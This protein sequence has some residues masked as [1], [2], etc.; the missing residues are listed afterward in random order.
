MRDRLKRVLSL[1][2]VFAI[3]TGNLLSLQNIS[4][5]KE[6]IVLSQGEE[7][8]IFD[9]SDNRIIGYSGEI[10]SKLE[11]PSEIDGVS[12]K[13]I[14]EEDKLDQD[15]I[16]KGI[17]ELVLPEGIE[18]IEQRVFFGNK[19]EKLELPKTL[20][21]IRGGAFK[22]NLI[23]EVNFP[24][25]IEEIRAAA[26]ENNK[27][28][29][30]NI[31]SNIE[32]I[33]DDAFKDN[34]LED[35]VIP[36]NIRE[37]GGG[38]FALNP[39]N[40][41]DLGRVEIIGGSAF[42]TTNL[43]EISLP[44]TL[45]EIGI[46]A[47]GNTRIEECI[48]PKNVEKL[49]KDAF[50]SKDIDVYTKI[51]LED[52]KNEHRLT[53]GVGTVLNPVEV[54]VINTSVDGE[55]SREKIVGQKSDGS[56]ITDYNR[57]NK[58][59]DFFSKEAEVGI[60]PKVI[61]GFL[62]PRSKTLKLVNSTETIEFKYEKGQEV[63]EKEIEVLLID[64]DYK[65]F[66]KVGDVYKLTLK[67]KN[68]VI[69]DVLKELEEK[70]NVRIKTE[71]GSYGEYIT[72][73][74]DLKASKAKSVMYNINDE[75][76]GLGASSQDVHDG[77]KILFFM[78][79]SMNG[80]NGPKWEEFTEEE[81]NELD[82]SKLIDEALTWSLVNNSKFEFSGATSLMV[83]G[84]D[85]K[86][87]PER[88][89]THF[90]FTYKAKP[91]NTI[92]NYLLGNNMEYLEEVKKYDFNQKLNN[93]NAIEPH[94]YSMIALNMIGEDYD[95]QLAS[96]NLVK[97][98]LSGDIKD[99]NMGDAIAA[100]V[101]SG[102]EVNKKE[103]LDNVN[104]RLSNP[105]ANIRYYS[106]LL[107][108][109]INLGEKV[110]ASSIEKLSEYKKDGGYATTPLMGYKKDG[111]ELIALKLFLTVDNKE[112]TFRTAGKKV[113]EGPSEK[114]DYKI[115]IDKSK[116]EFKE[117]DEIKIAAKTYLNGQEKD[118]PYDLVSEN[119]K[120]VSIA[121]DN[122]L[123]VNSHGTVTIK[124]ILK[125][126]KSAFDE[127]E[128]VIEKVE[129]KAGQG[130]INDF[131][132]AI[133][134][135]YNREH[136]KNNGGKLNAFEYATFEKVGLSSSR[137][138]VE[139]D[140]KPSYD[141][142][143]KYVGNKARQVEVMLATGRNPRDYKGRDLIEE[144]TT[145]I[146]TGK[147]DGRDFDFAAY[148]YLL[149]VVAVNNYNEIY[150]S[151]KANYNNEFVLNMI[152]KAQQENGGLIERS[153]E[154]GIAPRN[155]ALALE[156]VAKVNG[157]DDIKTKILSY[158]ESIQEDNGGFFEKAYITNYNADIVKA[159]A[160]AG[161]D[162]TSS[163]W[164]KG[165]YNPIESIFYLYRNN[166]SFKDFVGEDMSTLNNP[167]ERDLDCKV[168]TQA[169]LEALIE[170]R[171]NNG[172]YLVKT[173]KISETKEIV[174]QEVEINTSIIVLDKEG[175]FEVKNIPSKLKVNN[176]KQTAGLTALGALQAT[177]NN[178][179]MNYGFVEEIEGIRN[180]G[181]SGWMYSINGE[182]PRLAAAY[183]EVKEDD[184]IL[185]F[186]VP[187]ELLKDKTLEEIMPKWEELT[188][189]NSS[190]ILEEI[191][192]SIPRNLKQPMDSDVDKNVL[193][194]LDKII[195]DKGYSNIELKLVSV[196]KNDE[197]ASIDE[198][199][200]DI[201]YFY[202]HP[203]EV[204]GL[205]N[206]QRQCKI[207]LKLGNATKI[208]DANPS[209][210]WDKA[211][212]RKVIDEEIMEDLDSMIKG[213]NISLSQ[214]K[215]DSEVKDKIG[216][217]G[218]DYLEIQYKLEENA[219]LKFKK[220]GYE[221]INGKMVLT[222][223]KLVVKDV[224]EP[225]STKLK[226]VL[227]T[228]QGSIEVDTK[229]YNI[230][231]VPKDYAGKTL[232]EEMK[233][234]LE[235][236]YTEDKFKSA[237][238]GSEIDL[239]NISDDIKIPTPKETEIEDYDNYKYFMTSSDNGL[240][241]PFETKNA[242]KVVVYRPLP[243]ESAGKATLTINMEDKKTGT[244]VS[245]NLKEITVLP[246]TQEEIDKEIE[247]M[248]KVKSSYFDLIKGEN[249]SKDEITKDLK[250]FREV[251]L[252]KD[253]LT[254]NTHIKDDVNMGITPDA[255]EGWYDTEQW[256]LFRASNPEIIT[257]EN[258][259]VTRPEKDTKVK[260]D[261]ILTS[262]IYGK[263]AEKYPNN[264]DFKKLYKQAVEVE[265]TVLG[266]EANS[267][268]IDLDKEIN[269]LK[270]VFEAY[271]EEDSNGNTGNAKLSL[272]GTG[273]AKL[274]GMDMNKIQKNIY[275]DKDNKTSYQ[276]SQSII[277]LIGAD[278]DPTNYQ[279]RNLV[280]ELIK[281]QQLEGDE[282]GAFITDFR[283]IGDDLNSIEVQIRSII[284]L[285]M[286]GANYNKQAAVEKLIAMYENKEDNKTYKEIETEGYMIL[287][288]S[289]HKEL[290]QTTID[291]IV[292]N[293][294]SLQKDNGGYLVKGIGDG[295]TVGMSRVV[296]GLVA[297]GINPL[298]DERFIK[299]ENTIVDAILRNKV[300]KPEL[301]KSGY[302]K[303]AND[304]FNLAAGTHIVFG[305]L[306]D[307]KNEESMFHKLSNKEETST[308]KVNMSVVKFNL[309]G[310]YEI[311]SNP[312]EIELDQNKF[313]NK[314]TVLDALKVNG[315]DYELKGNMVT[316]IAGI[317]ETEEEGFK[318]SGWMYN[319]N[320]QAPEKDGLQLMA[321][322]AL[323]KDGD[324]I[325]WGRIFEFGRDTLPT[326][327]EIKSQEKEKLIS[328]NISSKLE[329]NKEFEIVARDENGNII[330]NSEVLYL[331]SDAQVAEIKD[332]KLLTK[333][334]GE[335][336]L[337]ASLKSDKNIKTSLKIQVE[338]ANSE[339]ENLKEY[340]A[341]MRAAYTNKD[342]F[343]FR[344]AMGYRYTS[345][346][347]EKDLKIISNKIE[348]REAESANNM[349][350]NIISIIAAGENPYNYKGVNYV[351]ML[352]K[353]QKDNGKFI[354]SNDDD[355][356]T[357]Q[358]FA[359]MALD[360]AKAE[361]KENTIEM[362]L[363][364]QNQDGSFS[365]WK[366]IDTVAMTLTAFAN[367]LN[368]EKV[369]EKMVKSIE[370][371]EN[372]NKLEA[373][374]PYTL[375]ALVQGLIA[376]E[377]DLDAGKWDKDGKKLV[378]RLIFSHKETLA[379]MVKPENA[380]MVNEQV[381]IALTDAEKGKSMFKEIKVNNNAI[382]EIQIKDL[383]IGKLVEGEEVQLEA[384]AKDSKGNLVTGAE[385][386][387]E[388]LNG[389][390]ASIDSNG[391]LFAKK[392]GEVNVIVKLKDSD[393]KAEKLIEIGKKEFDV[394]VTKPVLNL[395]QEAK[396][397]AK[398]KNL[399]NQKKEVTLI[400]ALV[401]TDTDEIVSYSKVRKV[402]KAGEVT[403]LES[404]LLVPKTGKYQIKTFLWDS[405]ENRNPIKVN[406]A[407]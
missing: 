142:N 111:E 380:L 310:K 389:D 396:A 330:D 284:A 322:Q 209:I 196:D 313:A 118:L 182:I 216:S 52:E 6:N 48:I 329:L 71:E 387:W 381:F 269:F 339:K 402:L 245:K 27:I 47:F 14:G 156:V 369:Q 16:Q 377:E 333:K 30:L 361:Y 321:D 93:I 23:R 170:I 63:E 185:W 77:D 11:I 161:E 332:N 357:T 29:T 314:A 134:I 115:E 164:T 210:L 229:E 140:Y 176:K 167:N 81:N 109:L 376:V 233:E 17:E 153:I 236:H 239:D 201:K 31:P 96:D 10:P 43:K 351:D 211:K 87:M 132:D 204:K 311:V 33:G 3:I 327:N 18:S 65:N 274:A 219:G 360:M 341:S 281:S 307:V 203:S 69:L 367:H 135:Y 8:F 316:K 110:D 294:S 101:D 76:A 121:R 160:I 214:F 89:E 246:L 346:N 337:T 268:K 5:A 342:K 129:A 40:T 124:A 242:G 13:H 213:E 46:S 228:V 224:K 345:E 180:S 326:M 138:E 372:K 171:K 278:L 146:N 336:T 334:A 335:F 298:T 133:S 305:A 264:E 82:L 266:T 358:A 198:V 70:H 151:N 390:I 257:H 100:I 212:L 51:Y 7:G 271:M 88:I 117:F 280:E 56:Y 165:E 370:F 143:L 364:Y 119:A 189:D 276:L 104:K 371:L 50:F 244:V 227:S 328:L 206:Q 80:Y 349:A 217:K 331:I 20:K 67:D 86:E 62:T 318:W 175:K 232:E 163:K 195:K 106:S 113:N 112:N 45:K 168:A 128:L 256:R 386:I 91:L 251:N 259:L 406:K 306:M 301:K 405:L 385:F 300:E 243:G 150:P 265:V 1:V 263:Y 120:I 25:D 303:K 190:E 166:N 149:G 139:K 172:D 169:A 136:F 247:L 237:V 15:F 394:E 130:N 12:V 340:V 178:I 200:G 325:V 215:V 61:E 355:Y 382:T 21:L 66:I 286:A 250:W 74:G 297:N 58:E 123:V 179:K 288:L 94:I 407:A 384:I 192:K 304:N 399:T 317:G 41:V 252:G 183:T 60:K 181:N 44:D 36:N 92:R 312:M 107:E 90:A 403:E 258:L 291:S 400:I 350:T 223:N 238:D 197:F 392:S 28:D 222:P 293:L 122:K 152:R 353:T 226:V 75:K 347:L 272:T 99:N 199:T 174:E 323:L 159:L 79:N 4:F 184:N 368:N 273:A 282:K 38:A 290:G 289:K 235:K 234:K 261:S 348:L 57:K 103:L 157:G 186:Y 279:T 137:W 398:V 255:L 249:I 22:N 98:I 320:G 299:N 177:T 404:G 231:V 220:G 9:K 2:L 131:I 225:I 19:I 108:A 359:V 73:I 270:S 275:I 59:F 147:S 127:I 194:V 145:V 32:K 241:K 309:D 144:I 155:T 102:A 202:K 375:S 173:A 207:E 267:S 125:E 193:E 26:F 285:D 366:D 365:S 302:A 42:H 141:E 54:E 354:F 283:G 105:P 208:I 191:A 187:E 97:Y 292:N 230:T 308:L 72:Q 248:E 401:N 362:L 343:T 262:V 379:T 383:N 221:Y 338:E 114:N 85:L 205:Y 374:N 78:G 315:L 24:E 35:I 83:A 260:I 324:N 154:N 352:Q 188:G 373:D 253:G 158:F 49:G 296:Q 391:K 53:S 397:I 148:P 254:W 363:A 393:M 295:A 64:H 344:E 39:I 356:A 55:L 68:P 378:D 126:D 37:I 388:V 287:A 116:F 34:F 277:T 84:K 319:L 162:L 240:I 218:Y 95:K 395:N